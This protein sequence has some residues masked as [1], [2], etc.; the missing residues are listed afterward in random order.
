MSETEPM[1]VNERRKYLHKMRIRYWQAESK[2][3][4]SALLDEM[5]NVTS[6]HR[7]SLIR[8]I[9]G[10]LARKPRR[11]QR[12][13]MY[14]AEIQSVV[15][16]IAHSLDYPCAE[17][18]QPNLVWMA[19]HLA[20]HAEIELNAD[21]QTKLTT[22]SVSTVRRLLPPSQRAAGRIAHSKRQPKGS[23]AQRQTIPMRHI[24][25]HESVPGHFEVDLV[26]HCGLSASGQYIHTLQMTDVATGWSE[27]VAILGRSY[28]VMQDGFQR[29]EK[30]LPFP[31]LEVH[32]DNG[33][34]FLN[35]HLVRFWQERAQPLELSRSRPYSKNDNRF[36]EENNFSQVRAYVGYNRLD[37][38]AQANLLNH[39]YDQLWLYHN[40]FQPVMRLNEKHF[41]NGHVKRMYDSAQTPL[42]RLCGTKKLTPPK[43]AQLQALRRSINPLQ[44]RK[45]IQDLI[46]KIF[47]LSCA[48]A[49]DSAEDVYLT[50]LPQE[51][52]L[53]R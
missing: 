53:S 9:K 17:R 43:Q 30:R 46:D 33:S 38:V 12:G 23:Y 21:I 26:H 6:L 29:I 36:V 2:S 51:A 25:W 28:L 16:Q 13:K 19:N 1:S 4:K 14:G 3:A 27:C 11:K 44:L 22:I 7:K 47:A 41:E 31:I 34:E 48:A 10:D 35:D 45:N 18:L 52:G 37:T 42:D 49:H 8:L 20:A 39:L 5:Q 40:F 32:P 24:P 50:L 15:E